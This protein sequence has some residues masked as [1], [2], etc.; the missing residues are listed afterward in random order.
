[1]IRPSV[2][3][4]PVRV[5][6]TSS[7]PL[8]AMAPSNAACPGAT[9]TG[10]DSPVSEA[11]SRL[12]VPARTMPSAGTRSPARSSTRSPGRRAAAGTLSTT[13][14]RSRRASV[15]V[16]RP[17][18]RI[19]SRE[20][21]RLRSSSTWPMIMTIGS[22]AAVI[23]SPLAQ[24]AISASAISRSAM[25]CRLGARRLCQAAISTGTATSDAAA[26][27]TR[28]ASAIPSGTASSQPTATSSSPAASMARVSRA[29]S[30]SRSARASTGA[31]DNPVT[32]APLMV[33]VPLAR[34]CRSWPPP[35][36]DQP[37][38]AMRIDGDYGAGLAQHAGNAL[39]IEPVE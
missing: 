38:A 22:S 37:A 39:A 6:S 12:A 1:M 17:S 30:S 36:Q 27:A 18:A 5:T 8:V 34:R 24:A 4:A 29:P 23:R 2:V 26:P 20:P 13:P 14:P 25:P 9:S 33:P 35:R 19:A 15:S 7:R 31:A 21:S 3:S 16:S 28:V 10:T 11:M 32:A